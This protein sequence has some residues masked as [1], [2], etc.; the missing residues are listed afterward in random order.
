MLVNL[1]VMSRRLRL[2][3]LDLTPVCDLGGLQIS[4]T[5]SFRFLALI[6]GGVIAALR[7]GKVPTVLIHA[8]EPALETAGL[9][10]LVFSPVRLG[11]GLG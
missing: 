2:G 10:G 5:L 8:S 3:F 9:E 6:G 7:Y 1:P 11:D 4:L